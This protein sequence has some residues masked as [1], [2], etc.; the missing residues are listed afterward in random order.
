MKSYHV[1]RSAS[2]PTGEHVIIEGGAEVTRDCDCPA[3]VVSATGPP[4]PAIP[5]L[6]QW[7]RG[8]LERLVTEFDR[9]YFDRAGAP[10]RRMSMFVS[11]F[12][13]EL[14]DLID[15][16]PFAAVVTLLSRMPFDQVTWCQLTNQMSMRMMPGRWAVITLPAFDGDDDPVYQSATEPAGDMPVTLWERAFTGEQA[17]A[18]YVRGQVRELLTG[19][20]GWKPTIAGTGALQDD[21]DSLTEAVLEQL[22]DFAAQLDDAAPA[23]ITGVCQVVAGCERPAIAGPACEVHNDGPNARLL[24]VEPA[25]GRSRAR[26]KPAAATAKKRIPPTKD[27][28]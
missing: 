11:A 18:D 6:M 9:G 8:E 12:Q 7:S 16:N 26:V 15:R 2:C 20:G 27:P 14:L 1:H 17:T 4:G 13:T 24:P 10:P 25:P 5:H 28:K 19:P 3:L 22:A 23:E 21:G